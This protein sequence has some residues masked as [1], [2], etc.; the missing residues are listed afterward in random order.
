[1]H[2]NAKKSPCFMEVIVMT[3]EK[4]KDKTVELNGMIQELNI[5]I[6]TY[7]LMKDWEVA[8]PM[9]MADKLMNAIMTTWDEMK[10]IVNED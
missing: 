1:M 4:M 3:I 5:M 2:R 8:V 7:E 9:N 6:G 10:K